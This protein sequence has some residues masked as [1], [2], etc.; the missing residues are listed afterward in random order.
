[1][2]ETLSV[3]PMDAAQLRALAHPLRLQLLE[4]LSSDGPATA[5]QLGRRLGES[6]GATSY[7]L[8][9]LHRAGMVE[10]AEQRNARERWWQRSQDSL[11]IPNSV[12]Q[13][14]SPAERAELQAAHSQI[15]SILVERDE[16]AM[17]RWMDVRYE[18]PLEW[19][20]A[21][22]IGNFRLWATAAEVREFVQAV[23]ELAEP[24]RKVPEK[25]DSQRLEAH[26]TFRVLPQERTP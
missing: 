1:M 10:E 2:A 15:E 8:R 7:H 6:S 9:A 16:N 25:A 14:A 3:R 20:D 22:W 13:D 26:F 19:Q 24:L 21:Q 23:I 11:L 18:L 12:P 17:R 4:L 5:S